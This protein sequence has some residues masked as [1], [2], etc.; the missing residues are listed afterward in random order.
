MAKDN[1]KL[2]KK[3]EEKP[4][5]V[6]SFDGTVMD[7]EPAIL[8]TYRELFDRHGKNDLFTKEI[9]LAALD[10]SVYSV[11]EYCFPE[12]DTKKM[13][14]EYNSWQ[15]NHLSDLIQPMHFI[16]DLL[17]WLKKHEY[18]IA[19]VSS[20]ERASVIE[21]L[22]H[23]R[24]MEYFDVVIGGKNSKKDNTSTSGLFTAL[25]LLDAKSCVYVSDSSAEI[26]IG[27]DAGVF[28]VGFA[29]NPDKARSIVDEKPDFVT[30]DLIQIK[31]LLKGEALWLAYEIQYPNL[32]EIKAKEQK[33]AKKK[34][35]KAK[36]KAD[37]AKEKIK[38][39]KTAEKNT[40][41]KVETKPV[42]KETAKKAI[43]KPASKKT[44]KKVTK[45]S[46]K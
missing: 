23:A 21:L 20:R 10:D 11:M 37:K 5:I 6:L 24:L 19:T 15:R 39:K 44:V 22:E 3:V 7:T 40:T 30:A 38:T 25:K 42:K 45:K 43:K 34:E 8:A 1:K 4:V 28:T 18:K 46:G 29:H 41:K 16:K 14:E 33:R 13:V 35:E 27:K 12:E 36:L 32:E 9:Q 17:K 31:K 26:M 2:A